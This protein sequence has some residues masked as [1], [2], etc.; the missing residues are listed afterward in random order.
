ML[1]DGLGMPIES[2]FSLTTGPDGSVHYLRSF[3]REGPE[4]DWSWESRR[5]AVQHDLGGRN[6]IFDTYTGK[7]DADLPT[8]SAVVVASKKAAVAAKYQSK[9]GN[10]AAAI[11]VKIAN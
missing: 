5:Q 8:E 9:Y 1:V 10:D 4:S 11:N 6:M 3:Y 7:V 2:S